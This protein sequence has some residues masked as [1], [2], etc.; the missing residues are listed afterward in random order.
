MIVRV[1][2]VPLLV[3]EMVTGVG[4]ATGRPRI[5]MDAELEPGGM[6]TT[7][8]GWPPGSRTA[9]GLFVVNVTFWP[10][11]ATTGA[12]RS[13]R[14]DVCTV[15]LIAERLVVSEIGSVE[16]ARTPKYGVSFPPASYES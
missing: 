12:F 5:L 3:A 9:D 7:R 11:G 2:V 4:A 13:I 16:N 6:F 10:P 14:H 8:D 1:T 15:G